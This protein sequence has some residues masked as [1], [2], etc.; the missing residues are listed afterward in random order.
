MSIAITDDHRAL[1]KTASDFL[2]KNGARGAARALLEAQADQLPDFWPEMA[3]LG[4]LGLHLPEEHGGSGFGLPELAVVVEELGRAV[5]PGPFVPTVIASAVLSA[6]GSP[7]L[8]ERLLP[9]LA[10]GSLVGAVALGGDVAVRGGSGD[11]TGP[12]ATASGSAGVVIAG[13]LADVLL[14]PAGEDVV[15]V[16]KA[17]GG[18][19]AKV[20]ANVDPA[21]R[22]ARVTLDGAPAVVLPGGR[23]VLTNLARLILSAEATGV[24]RECT[25]QSTPRY[26]SSSAGRS[27]P[28]RR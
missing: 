26:A 10:D 22:A 15:V 24:A 25:V 21:R 20:P 9:G 18:I 4:W 23:R 28:S 14:V 11:G 16:E 7:D 2:A 19:T 1:A 27:P 6:I 12:G 3:K 8:A 5:A 13:H 17:A